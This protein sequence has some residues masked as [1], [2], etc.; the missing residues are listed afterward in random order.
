MN[1]ALH[2]GMF[3]HTWP[4]G[5]GDLRDEEGGGEWWYSGESRPIRREAIR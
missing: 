1:R 5:Y 3:G 4:F 2:D